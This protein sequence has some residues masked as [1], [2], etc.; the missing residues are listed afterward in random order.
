MC[1]RVHIIVFGRR[2]FGLDKKK[3]IW[4]IIL[5]ANMHDRPFIDSR[6]CVC[7]ITPL[8]QSVS[9]KYTLKYGCLFILYFVFFAPVYIINKVDYNKLIYST[10]IV[11][12]HSVIWSTNV[13]FIHLHRLEAIERMCGRHDIRARVVWLLKQ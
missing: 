3:I 1:T 11:L 13:K 9:R 8:V 12:A 5:Y 2:R 10:F 4:Y 6:V 7:R